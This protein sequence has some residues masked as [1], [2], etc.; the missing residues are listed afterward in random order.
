MAYLLKNT[1]DDKKGNNLL[2]AEARVLLA[3]GRLGFIHYH[4]LLH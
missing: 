4:V 1:K 2:F 3:A